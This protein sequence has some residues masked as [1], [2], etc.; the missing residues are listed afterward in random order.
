[1]KKLLVII[2]LLVSFVLYFCKGKEQ[3]SGVDPKLIH[4]KWQIYVSPEDKKKMK[5][6]MQKLFFVF[7]KDGT[8]VFYYYNI[9]FKTGSQYARRDREF[10]YEILDRKIKIHWIENKRTDLWP[11]SLREKNTF[12]ILSDPTPGNTITYALQRVDDNEE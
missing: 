3:N 12:L 9:D 4:G 11:F 1:M 8:G 7:R 5:T 2:I 10:K 6:G